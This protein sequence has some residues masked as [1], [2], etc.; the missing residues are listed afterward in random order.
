MPSSKPCFRAGQLGD[1]RVRCAAVVEERHDG[2]KA[3]ATELKGV[4]A[5]LG[6][7]RQEHATLKAHSTSIR[8]PCQF[9][10]HLEFGPAA[11]LPTP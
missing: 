10:K 1:G 4:E 6:I 11:F 8:I 3:T 9:K 7:P 5:H 2:Q